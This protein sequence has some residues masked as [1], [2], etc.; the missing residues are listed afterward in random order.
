MSSLAR[1]FLAVEVAAGGQHSA[2]V[3]AQARSFSSRLFHHA[4]SGANS[5][6]LDGGGLWCSSS[7]PRAA[8][9][10]NTRL[11][12]RPGASKE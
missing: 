10:R 11:R 1:G 3:R 6:K 5:S 4:I 12:A 8:A 2:A 7:A 9:V